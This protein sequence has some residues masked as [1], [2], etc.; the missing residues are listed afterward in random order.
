MSNWNWLGLPVQASEHAARMDTFNELVHL[1]IIAGF[2]FWTTWF[3]AALLKFGKKKNP[4]AD[5]HGIRSNWP[6]IP[7]G[8][9]VIFDFVLLF[10]LSMPYWHDQI[11]TV[12]KPGEDVIE[13]RVVAQQFEWNIHYPGKDGIFGRTDLTLIDDQFNALG[14][15]REDPNGKDDVISRNIMHLPVNRQVLIHLSSKDMVHSFSLPEFRIK[16]DVIPGMRIPIYFTPTM[17]SEEFA[18][19]SGHPERGFEIACAQLCGN[20]HYDMRGYITVESSEAYETWL[21]AEVEARLDAA[22]DDWFFEN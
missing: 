19:A 21:E 2:L 7:I 20:S 14:L 11:N 9:M 10:G 5:Y 22:E 1:V 6:Y 13:I 16:Q 15:D 4:D 3:I 8:I 18:A 12:P 17:T